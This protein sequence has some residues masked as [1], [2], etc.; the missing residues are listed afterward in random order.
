VL[1]PPIRER[2]FWVVQGLI[3]LATI[4]HSTTELWDPLQTPSGEHLFVV[5]MYGLYTLPIVYA[6][7]IF[8]RNGAAPTAIVMA[9]LS[10]PNILFIHHGYDRWADGLQHVVII[11]IALVI[12]DR[13]DREI[14][15]R[16]SA[17][18]AAAGRRASEARY[19]S[20]FN[21]VAEPILVFDR[22]GRIAE[23]NAA[24]VSLFG[25]DG[26]M[27]RSQFLREVVGAEM[28][29]KLKTPNDEA[30]SN[31]G[32]MR[33][34]QPDGTER[35][36]EP[37]WNLVPGQNDSPLIQS[38]FLDVTAQ[39]RRQRGL[40]AYARQ[41]VA[42]QEEERRRIARELHD[43]PLQGIILLCRHLDTLAADRGQSGTFV[44]QDLKGAR[45]TAELLA[46]E[47]RRLSRDLRPSI[48]DDLGLVPAL[49]W[50]LKDLEKRTHIRTKFVVSDSDR[51]V[52]ASTE[53]GLF[54]IAQE[55]L[56]NVER[57]ARASEVV[58][59]LTIDDHGECLVVTDN[60]DGMG[61][62]D[63]GPSAASAGKLGLLGMQDRA[64]LCGGELTIQTA[65]GRGTTI[66][67]RIP[68]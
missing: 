2:G 50:L 53:L 43:G 30:R 11:G 26:A 65:L 41:V 6:S 15:A 35:W 51:R 47:I 21:G 23:A 28:A 36:L 5:V 7:L 61:S 42:A 12:A 56:R 63:L 34:L 59:T 16:Q 40:E 54:R 52:P 31:S 64:R 22:S 60:G 8:G 48:L 68:S 13:V 24:A 46:D 17:E 27:L 32:L 25:S 10:L 29:A 66:D 3:L 14:V 58:V 44:D 37:V 4:V 39:Q 1:H 18:Q 33:R 67:V 20:L 19:R 38:M 62:V 57:H 9:L 49:R 55:A 45:H